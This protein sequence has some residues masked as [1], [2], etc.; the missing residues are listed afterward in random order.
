MPCHDSAQQQASLLSSCCGN[1][2]ASTVPPGLH[3]GRKRSVLLLMAGIG[4]SI[5]YQYG[6]SALMLNDRLPS[7]LFLRGYWL[8]DCTAEYGARDAAA[9][10]SNNTSNTNNNVNNTIDDSFVRGCVEQ[11]ANYRVAAAT[12][13]FF[14]LAGVAALCKP[15]ANREAWPAKF[16]LYLFLIVATIFIPAQFWLSAVFL[17]V[18]RGTCSC[19]YKPNQPGACWTVPWCLTLSFSLSL[20]HTHTHTHTHTKQPN[21]N[22]R[23]CVVY[24]LSTIGHCGCIVSVE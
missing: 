10:N 18:A 21:Y 1:D 24:L 8:D 11:Q 4:L 7:Q 16:I 22:S 5:I 12:T 6:L 3:S 13:L 2:K 14:I 23:W 19:E 9:N 20:S 17:N 15:T